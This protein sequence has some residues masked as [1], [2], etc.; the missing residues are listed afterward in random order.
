MVVSNPWR[1]PLYDGDENHELNH[2][3][4]LG[5]PHDYGKPQNQRLSL[6]WL[7]EKL[8]PITLVFTMTNST[9]WV[10]DKHLE[11]HG[12]LPTKTQPT[13]SCSQK[14]RLRWWGTMA[15]SLPAVLLLQRLRYTNLGGF[16]AAKSCQVVAKPRLGRWPKWGQQLHCWDPGRCRPRSA[17]TFDILL[18]CASRN[19]HQILSPKKIRFKEQKA[20]VD[21][22]QICLLPAQKMEMKESTSSPLPST[23]HWMVPHS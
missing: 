11:S 13:K 21:R 9:D 6:D 18:S 2:P 16:F 10:E 4:F 1:V 5:Y 17:D 14:G 3:A 22:F 20:K 8:W 12:S 7:Q 15:K 23:Y 19:S